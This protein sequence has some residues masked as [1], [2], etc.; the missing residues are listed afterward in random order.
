MPTP[1]MTAPSPPCGGAWPAG[2]EAAAVGAAAAAEAAPSTPSGM[3]CGP[4]LATI[5]PLSVTVSSIT[6]CMVPQLG[7][8][9]TLTVCQS[10]G[11]CHLPVE[12]T[13]VNARS[14]VQLPIQSA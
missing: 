11:N 6:I 7:G 10:A 3:V 14:A 8:T 13:S 9:A 5:W 1:G 12:S 2:G 4:A